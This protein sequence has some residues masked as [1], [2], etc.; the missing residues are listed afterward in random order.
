A[1]LTVG[2]VGTIFN[3]VPVFGTVTAGDYTLIDVAGRVFL[4]SRR[5]HRINIR[6]ENL[7]DQ[8]YTTRNARNF[9]DGDSTPYLVNNLG[10]PLTFH[11][12]YSVGF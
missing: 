2:H 4:D 6:L 7:F 3:T 11:L 5:R 12:T 10:V 1:T 9:L 8:V